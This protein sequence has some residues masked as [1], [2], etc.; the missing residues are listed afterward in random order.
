MV[1]SC[2]VS[3]NDHN[4]ATLQPESSSPTLSLTITADGK[5]PAAPASIR[6]D[7]EMDTLETIEIIIDGTRLLGGESTPTLLGKDTAFLPASRLFT[8]EHFEPRADGSCLARYVRKQPSSEEPV[9]PP[10]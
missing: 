7:A 2:D 8:L 10:H 9:N 3:K 6:A 4:I 1:K 5:C